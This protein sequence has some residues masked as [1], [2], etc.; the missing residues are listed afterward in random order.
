M[1]FVWWCWQSRVLDWCQCSWSRRR[2]GESFILVREALAS[3]AWL[4]QPGSTTGSSVHTG[5]RLVS[6]IYMEF[7]IF[8]SSSPPTAPLSSS[9][10][11]MWSTIC[12][13]SFQYSSTTHQTSLSWGCPM[14]QLLI[15]LIWKMKNVNENLK[16]WKS[17]IVCTIY[18]TLW[19]LCCCKFCLAL[20]DFKFE[21][22]QEFSRSLPCLHLP[23][24]QSNVYRQVPD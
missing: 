7:G 15:K 13:R 12:R 20:K 10:T 18:F 22:N 16:I 2:T 17:F 4:S 21:V 19:S 3:S 24:K 8:W 5:Q 1:H 14:S 11:V 23:A 9:P 6:H